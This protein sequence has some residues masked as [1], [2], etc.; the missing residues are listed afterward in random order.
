MSPSLADR[1][2][3]HAANLRPSERAKRLAP[4][5]V[6][7]AIEQ[8]L[9]ARMAKTPAEAELLELEAVWATQAADL[10]ATLETEQW[11]QREASKLFLC[12]QIDRQELRAITEG[13]NI[14]NP[15][16]AGGGSNGD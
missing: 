2:R 7:L 10:L 4:K 8:R 1:E 14:S 3:Q 5:L 6:D 13:W 9:R 15:P 16:S 11:R 12:G